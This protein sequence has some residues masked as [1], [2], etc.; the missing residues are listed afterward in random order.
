[1][2]AADDD[3]YHWREILTELRELRISVAILAEQLKPIT[4]HEERLRAVERR[5]WALPSLATLVAVVALIKNW[6]PT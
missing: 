2:M 5:I 4:D 6:I 1:M 3:E